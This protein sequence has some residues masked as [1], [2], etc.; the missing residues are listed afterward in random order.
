MVDKATSEG[1]DEE[2]VLQEKNDSQD[3]EQAD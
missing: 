1:I 3:K 2:T